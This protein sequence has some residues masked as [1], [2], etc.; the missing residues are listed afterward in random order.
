MRGRLKG[1]KRGVTTKVKK[2]P[3]SDDENR[4]TVRLALRKIE[5]EEGKDNVR[6]LR[7]VCMLGGEEPGGC[8]L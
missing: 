7:G 4:N 2:A 3:Q 8:P 5:I 1:G 6:A